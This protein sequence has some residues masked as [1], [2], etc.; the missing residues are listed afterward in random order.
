MG[1]TSFTFVLYIL[2]FASIFYFQNKTLRKATLLI[3]SILFYLSFSTIGFLYLVFISVFTYYISKNI[4]KSSFILGLLVLVLGLIVLKVNFFYLNDEFISFIGVSFFSFKAIG[5]LIDVY[6]NKIKVVDSFFDY[7]IYISFFPTI[8]AGPIQKAQDFMVDLDNIGK[9]IPYED[10]KTGFL[11]L[12]LG[13]FEKV[14]IV[15]RISIL[16]DY[17][18]ETQASL[19]I[20]ILLLILFS[21]KIYL[22][23]DSY[24]NIA[25][26][27][28][29]MF[30]FNVKANFKSPYLSKNLRQFWR[31]WHISLS[32]F[33]KDYVYIPL[34]GNKKGKMIQYINVLIVS[35]LS[36]LWH[37]INLGC[38]IWGLLHGLGQIVFDKADSFFKDSLIKTI[39][40]TVLTFSFV[41][42]VWL[43]F[44]GNSFEYFNYFI[45]SVKLG[46][47]SGLNIPNINFPDIKATLILL[48]IMIVLDYFRYKYNVLE[49]FNKLNI[50]IRW[51]FYIALIFTFLLLG[52][53]G[54]TYNASDFIYWQF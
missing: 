42:F 17:I 8:T 29:K 6:N 43:F 9:D 39:I 49:Y 50:V 44:L 27:C 18:M 53:Y 33:F 34:G 54:S 4:N 31:R 40:S 25:I 15:E 48:V 26:G 32:T 51:I 5:Y 11:L 38:F 10:L 12:C 46:F 37:G 41:S 7:F 23:F 13:I 36:G 20:M 30:G 35:I 3:A 16:I 52:T 19:D 22:D 14:V 21:Y 45:D 24:S 1:I 2:L 28:S 47:S